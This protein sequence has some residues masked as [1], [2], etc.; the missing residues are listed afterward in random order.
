MPPVISCCMRIACFFERYIMRTIG[1]LELRSLQL[2]L[3]RSTATSA[4]TV[5]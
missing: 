2:S 4:G 1:R 5:A 3:C